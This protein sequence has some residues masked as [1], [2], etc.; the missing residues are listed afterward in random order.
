MPTAAAIVPGPH[1]ERTELLDGA[2]WP[3]SGRSEPHVYAV[4]RVFRALVVRFDFP[5]VRA[6]GP[7]R[8]DERNEPEPDLAVTRAVAEHYLIHGSPPLEDVRLAIEVSDSTLQK[9]LT[10]KAALYAR[11][12]L[13]DYWVLDLNARRLFVHRAPNPDGYTDV[14][15]YTAPES[16]APLS[17]PHHPIRIADLLPPLSPPSE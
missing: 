5:Y 10:R 7:I 17:A 13:T 12:G 6:R 9:D 1:P 11:G 15:A 16:V 3:T 4:L 8:F 14:L 2:I